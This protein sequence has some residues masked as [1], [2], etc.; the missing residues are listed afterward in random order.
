VNDQAA[1]SDHRPLLAE[2]LTRHT[3]VAVQAG[4]VAALGGGAYDGSVP[5]VHAL[6]VPVGAFFVDFSRPEILTVYVA[7]EA[8]LVRYEMSADGRALSVLV[9]LGRVTRVAFAVD[10]SG[11]ASLAIELDAD[12]ATVIAGV[13]GDEGRPGFV[14]RA[15]FTVSVPADPA[16]LAGFASALN[17]LLA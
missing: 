5:L 9:P 16:G 12:R 3:S 7:T 8:A 1:V 14:Q 4:V 15:G 10:P 13:P 11:A 2:A 17:A 6:P